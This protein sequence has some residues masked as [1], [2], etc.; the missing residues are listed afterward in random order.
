MFAT[1]AT[2]GIVIAILAVAIRALTARGKTRKMPPGP[3]GLPI[4]GNVGGVATSHP[5]LY[6][7]ELNKKYGEYRALHHCLHS[8]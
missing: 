3:K 2:V 6:Y 8:V 5:H 7:T 1:T 4:I